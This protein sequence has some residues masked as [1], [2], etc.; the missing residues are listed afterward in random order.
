MF[1]VSTI[2][3]KCRQIAHLP[4]KTPRVKKIN[5]LVNSRKQQKYFSL[6]FIPSYSGGKTRSVQIPQ[7]A[8]V[9]AICALAM[10]IATIGGFY[11]RGRYFQSMTQHVSASLDETKVTLDDFRENAEN[12]RIQL[13]ES[14]L[15]MYLTLTREPARLQAE[16]ERQQTE[17]ANNIEST[18]A[19]IESLEQQ[20]LSFESERVELLE[21]L[22]NRVEQIPPIESTV[23]QLVESQENLLAATSAA[24]ASAPSVAYP[25][26]P[27]MQLMSTVAAQSSADTLVSRIATASQELEMQRLLFDDIETH[28]SQINSYLQNYPTL[29][30]IDGGVI[31]SYFGS[32]IDPITGATAFHYAVDIPA[33]S[34]TPIRA[35][36][37]GVVSF[38]GWR[39]GYGN[40]IYLDHGNGMETR[41]AHN[42]E[43]LVTE[44]QVVAR[45]EI[46]AKV[47]IT[48]RAISNHV[49]YEVLENGRL[50]NPVPFITENYEVNK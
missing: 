29:M 23:L 36:G 21:F 3:E 50:V 42:S 22:S 27:I 5:E 12:A 13:K 19:H 44:G 28:K 17:H 37:G 39:T 24:P 26:L 40:V 1:S 47:G 2:S 35:T 10:V 18:M 6:I 31:T 32:R 45:G 15:E 16:L 46:I 43:N 14:T 9:V 7:I 11:L 30:P 33:P 49:H 8:C 25:Q 38:V 20:L 34:G 4:T 41:Y 48:G